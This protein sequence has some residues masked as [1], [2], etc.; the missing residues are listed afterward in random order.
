MMLASTR[1]PAGED[2]LR[3]PTAT[4]QHPPAGACTVLVKA[5]S[6]ATSKAAPATTVAVMPMTNARASP[7]HRAT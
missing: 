4:P 6:T 2:V 1:L 7:C 3:A 5:I